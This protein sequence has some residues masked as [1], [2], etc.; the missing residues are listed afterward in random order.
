LLNAVTKNE[1]TITYLHQNP[2]NRR[3]PND[4]S[5]ILRTWSLLFFGVLHV[6][7][8]WR[9]TTHRVIPVL[10]TSYATPRACRAPARTQA[11]H[12][13]PSDLRSGTRVGRLLWHFRTSLKLASRQR[14]DPPGPGS[15]GRPLQVGDRGGEGT[16]PALLVRE[17]LTAA[18]GTGWSNDSAS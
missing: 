18:P 7:R 9:Q 1:N 5:Y 2:S 12:C 14:H 10:C 17:R 3:C 15:G 8:L 4:K 16:A 13:P 6:R 11:Y